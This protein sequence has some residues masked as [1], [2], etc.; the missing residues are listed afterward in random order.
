MSE[1]ATT[2]SYLDPATIASVGSIDVRARMIVEGLMTGMHRSPMQGF[3]VEFAQHRQYVPGDDTRF[4][5]WKV[6]GRSDKLYIKQYLKETNLDLV[7]LCDASG[8]M[9]YCSPMTRKELAAGWRKFDH[10]ATLAAVM[11]HL[12]LKQQDR[13]Q[14]TLFDEDIRMQTRLSNARGHWREVVRVLEEAPLPDPDHAARKLASDPDEGLGRTSLARTFDRVLS[15]LTQRS[16]ILLISDLMDDPKAIEKALARAHHRRH[17]VMIVQTLDSA[18]RDFP[19]RAPSEFIGLEA[20]GRLPIS[21][22]A[23]RKAYLETMNHHLEQ[24]DEAAKKFQFDLMRLST[25]EPV[26]PPLS[27]FLA[28]RAAVIGKRT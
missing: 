14:V 24:T 21:P 27:H 3:S 4:L 23:L 28:R 26:G 15:K 13:V 6:F 9:A 20:E 8:S 12:A 5:D 17:D 22:E 2:T 7:I 11:A 16:L 10:A 18:E 19:F 1:T 25:N